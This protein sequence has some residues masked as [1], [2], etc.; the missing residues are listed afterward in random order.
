MDEQWSYIRPDQ[1]VEDAKALDRWWPTREMAEHDR[2]LDVAW[3][4]LHG[5]DAFVRSWTAGG[6]KIVK[7]QVTDWEVVK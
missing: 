1:R 7:R 5:K 6:Y 2:D 4:R 3:A